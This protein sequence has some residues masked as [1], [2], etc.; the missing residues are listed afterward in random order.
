MNKP[1]QRQVEYG[2]FANIAFFTNDKYEK[3]AYCLST[4]INRIVRHKQINPKVRSCLAW[5][6]DKNIFSFRTYQTVQFSDVDCSPKI[7]VHFSGDSM[8]GC[9]YY[10]IDP[11][12]GRLIIRPIWKPK[13]F[14]SDFWMLRSYPVWFSDHSS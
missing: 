12:S 1:V 2:N 11:I 13:Q 14:V 7:K 8:V 5:Y 9:T 3:F 4:E 10:N 6:P